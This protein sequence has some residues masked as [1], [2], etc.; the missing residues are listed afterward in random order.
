MKSILIQRTSRRALWA[1]A[2]LALGTAHLPAL[3]QAPSAPGAAMP[4]MHAGSAASAG[5]QA[6][7]HSMM[8]SM[9]TMHE[10]KPT[11]DTD[12]DFATM[13]KMHHEQALGMARIELQHGKSP[14]LKAMARKMIKDQ[15]RE[16]GQLDAW[17]KRKP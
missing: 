8:G 14:Q 11:G 9:Q 3:S 16:I 15:T 1:A 7:H 10:M 6:L 17:L 2:L 13:M 4:A 5:S 12:R